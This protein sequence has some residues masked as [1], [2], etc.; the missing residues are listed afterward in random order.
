MRTTGIITGLI[1]SLSLVIM[2]GMARCEEL[3]ESYYPLQEGMR[4]EYVVISDKSDTKKLIITNLAP[5]EVDGKQVAPRKWDLGGH[6][7][8]EFMEKEESG[9]YR[10]AE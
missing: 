3:G 8:I 6:S 9:I 7:F 4:W 5:R 1:L 10:Y 2:S